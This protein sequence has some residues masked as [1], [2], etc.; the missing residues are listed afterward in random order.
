M[1]KIILCTLSLLCCLSCGKTHEPDTDQEDSY[2]D[3]LDQMREV[4]CGEWKH[5]KTEFNDN[6]DVHD[7]YVGGTIY[8]DYNQDVIINNTLAGYWDIIYNPASD[9]LNQY[10]GCLHFQNKGVDRENWTSN[11]RE[12]QRYLIYGLSCANVFREHLSGN[13]LTLRSVWGSGS[14]Q[15]IYL[16]RG[17]SGG[18][19]DNK[20]EEPRVG[21][22]NWTSTKT[23]ISLRYEIYNQDESKVSSAKIYYGE[24]KNSTK[25][26]T[27]DVIGHTIQTTIK[28]LKPGTDYYV[29]CVAKGKNGSCTTEWTRCLTAYE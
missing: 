7:K 2:E 18:T 1:K 4:I 5:I 14:S 12:A 25:S 21:L 10:I 23:S 6:S 19:G 22:G 15:A 24:D 16:E 28:G 26:K 17:S 11:D 20:Y 13:K 8:F 27:A 3:L 29:K 9:E